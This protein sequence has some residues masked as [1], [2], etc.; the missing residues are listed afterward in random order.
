MNIIGARLNRVTSLV[1]TVLA[2]TT[3]LLVGAIIIILS[4]LEALGN[5]D[6]GKQLAEV[7]SAYFALLN[8]SFGSLRAVSETID[9]STPLI[10]SGI[11][12]AMAFKAGLFNIGATGQMMAGGLAATWVGFIMDGPGFVQIPL[13]LLAALV[14]GALIGAIP[15]FLK[16]RTGAHEVITTIM[17]NYICGFL[18][19]WAL[20]TRVFQ[21]ADRTDPISKFVSAK[22]RLPDLLGFI[23]GS[24]NFPHIGILIALL[25]VVVY[26]WF[27]E[28]SKIGFEFRV[29][30]Q[31]PEA[32]RYAGMRPKYLTVLGMVF[33]GALAGLAGGIEILGR[34]GY[35]TQTFAGTI[36][37]DAI[38]I[39]LLGRSSPI[40]TLISAILFG[41]LQS[42][43]REMQ[44]ATDISIDMIVVIRALIVMFI[45]APLLIKWI[46]RLRFSDVETGPTFKG[47]GS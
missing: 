12:V 43:G 7:G 36:G 10:I 33:A 9:N 8:G 46:W 16:A 47:W 5:G 13:A 3:A 44:V 26:W 34:Y 19:L 14:G 37:F 42:G 28:R 18:L 6:F 30:G 15:G 40:G 39:A 32:A 25:T 45:A 27:L 1:I 17:L 29:Y 41:A 4:N 22:S 20:D 11:S 35:T 24:S 2:V 31:N 21:R 23:N 38:A